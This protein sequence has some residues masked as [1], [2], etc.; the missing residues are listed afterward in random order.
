MSD[1]A[2]TPADQFKPI[3]VPAFLRPFP[4]L[5]AE[6][7]KRALAL[8]RAKA[9]GTAI[10]LKW[11]CGQRSALGAITELEEKNWSATTLGSQEQDRENPALK[12]LYA[13]LKI[14]EEADA[15]LL[16]ILRDPSGGTFIEWSDFDPDAPVTF[17]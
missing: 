9:E 17:G 13:A 7:M 2:A 16:A 4:E 15:A 10:L 11:A 14:I 3:V 1:S 6:Y 8:A 5:V 12:V